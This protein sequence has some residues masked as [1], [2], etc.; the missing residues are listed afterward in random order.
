M[1]AVRRGFTNPFRNKARAVLVIGLLALVT[2]FLALMVQASLAS[3]Q[4]IA[5]M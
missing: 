1:S 3:R 2:G 4:Q 5:S